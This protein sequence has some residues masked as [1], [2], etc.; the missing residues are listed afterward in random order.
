VPHS[1]LVK[2][3][4]DNPSVKMNAFGRASMNNRLRV[5]VQRR[6]IVPKMLE[7]GGDLSGCRVLELGCGR[8]V[9]L[10]LLRSQMQAKEVIGIDIDARMLRKSSGGGPVAIADMTALPIA[11]GRFDAV[12][13]FGALHLVPEWPQALREVQR[14][15]RPGGRYYFEQ[16]V[17]RLFRAVMPIATGRRIPGGFSRDSYLRELASVG[18]EVEETRAP[19]LMVLTGVASDLMG[20]ARKT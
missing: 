5:A 13:D 9:G 15:L 19:R 2:L 17:G 12:V 3:E 14:V 11:D 8:G 4:N 20:C 1:T 6:Y 16:I 7:M 10:R 18:L